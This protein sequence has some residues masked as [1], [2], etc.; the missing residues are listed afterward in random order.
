MEMERPRPIPGSHVVL[1]VADF[2][3]A[4]MA[5]ILITAIVGARAVMIETAPAQEAVWLVLVRSCG[6]ASLVHAAEAGLFELLVARS[7]GIC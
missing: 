4:S 6:P 7:H 5:V 3:R 2:S 1:Q